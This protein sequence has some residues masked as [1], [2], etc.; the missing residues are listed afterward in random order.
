MRSNQITVTYPRGGKDIRTELAHLRTLR[1]ISVSAFCR[2][3][4]EKGL[5]MEASEL[6]EK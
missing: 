2:M 5:Q 3:W 4:I 1:G 6:P